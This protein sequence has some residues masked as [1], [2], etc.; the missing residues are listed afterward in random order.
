MHGRVPVVAAEEGRG[1]LA[2]RPGIGVARHHVLDLPRVLP[3]DAREREAG[4][5]LHESALDAFGRGSA[6]RALTSS[7]SLSGHSGGG[8]R[9][10]SRH[11]GRALGRSGGSACCQRG[12][13]ADAAMLRHR[14]DR[15]R[16]SARCERRHDGSPDPQPPRARASV[17]WAPRPAAWG[18]SAV[19]R[20]GR[21]RRRGGDSGAGRRSPSAQRSVSGA[22]AVRGRA[23]TGGGTY[24]RRAR[25]A[26]ARSVMG[27]AP[28]PAAL[29]EPSIHRRALFDIGLSARG[30]SACSTPS[31]G[32]PRPGR[33]RGS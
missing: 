18:R 8:A 17:R 3:V 30:A 1:Q 12:H 25:M 20:Q 19:R 33:G 28:G 21:P 6:R 24:G 16:G 4:E 26:A 9:D 15:S 2:G 13:V 27:P 23:G 22:A 32:A 11:E 10:Q 14:H 7:R 31:A 29:R 5:A